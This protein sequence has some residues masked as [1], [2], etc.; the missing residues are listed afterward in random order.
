MGMNLRDYARYGS[1]GISWVLSSLVYA[2]LGF[3]GGTWLDNRYGT[4]PLF[5]LLCLLAALGMSLYSL[6]QELLRIEKAWKKE[7]DAKT[8]DSQGKERD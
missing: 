5:V 3:K 8:K 7:K 4:D 6:I 2:Y 1:I